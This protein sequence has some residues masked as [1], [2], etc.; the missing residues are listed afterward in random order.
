MSV[1]VNHALHYLPLLPT[2]LTTHTHQGYTEDLFFLQDENKENQKYGL[3][4]N[5]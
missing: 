4:Y 2:Y 5:L 3:L 1:S